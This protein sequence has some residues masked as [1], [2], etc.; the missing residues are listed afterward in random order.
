M[1]ACVCT[2][3]HKACFSHLRGCKSIH[4]FLYLYIY[5]YIFSI[6]TYMPTYVIHVSLYIYIYI[7]TYTRWPRGIC[8][9]CHLWASPRNLPPQKKKK[10]GDENFSPSCHKP[11]LQ[12]LPN[13]HGFVSRPPR[14]PRPPRL[15]QGLW[16]SSVELET[17]AFLGLNL[18]SEEKQALAI[19][20][21]QINQVGRGR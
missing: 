15:S 9:T 14:P 16:P 12:L 11:M 8:L 1:R 20:P 18:N 13:R 3:L 2:Y 21:T 17:S 4:L 19:G 7:Y 10:N 6:S 5:I